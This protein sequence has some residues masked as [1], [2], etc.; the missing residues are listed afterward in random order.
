MKTNNILVLG[1][2]LLATEILNQRNWSQI[3]R[4]KDDFDITELYDCD[5]MLEGYDVIVNCIGFTDTYSDDLLSHWQINYQGVASLVD[6]CNFNGQKIVQ[7]STDY[8]YS[9]S[10][11]NASELDVPVHCQNYYG[12]TKLLADGYVQLKAENYLLV[13]T[14]FKP[15]PFPY[16][17]ALV[18][19]FGNFDYVDVIA[20]MI[21][22]LIEKDAEGVYNVGTERKNIYDLARQTRLD[23]DPLFG[24]LHPSMPMEVSMNLEK[25]HKFLEEND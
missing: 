21:I 18:S 9:G 23:V 24:K 17:K 10:K 4:K 16:Q 22:D 19:Q 8:L 7:I 6:T 14:S 3:S 15:K 5:Y 1:D 11:D 20:K 12:Y 2:G 13:R 25:L